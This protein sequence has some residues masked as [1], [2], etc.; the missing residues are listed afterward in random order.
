MPKIAILDDAGV[1]LVEKTITQDAWNTRLGPAIEM[2]LPKQEEESG[3]EHAIRWIK[4]IAVK[5]IHMYERT[6]AAEAVAADENVLQ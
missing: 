6:Q 1:V 4:T 5:L 3:P 2:N